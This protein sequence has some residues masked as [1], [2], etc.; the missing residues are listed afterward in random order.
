VRSQA[1]IDMDLPSR[2][3][4]TIEI[5]NVLGQRVQTMERTMSAGAGQTIQLDGSKLSSGQYF[6]RVKANFE[7]ETARETGRITV[8][9]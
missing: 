2:T 1:T 9:K 4:V 6:Y 3:D 8:V 7:G 5:Y